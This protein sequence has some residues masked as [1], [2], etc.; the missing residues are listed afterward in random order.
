MLIHKLWDGSEVFRQEGTIYIPFPYPRLVISNS[1]INSGY[2]EDITG[3][4]NH[5]MSPDELEKDNFSQER[6]IQYLEQIALKHDLEKGHTVGMLTAAKMENV[7]IRTMD[8]KELAVTAIVTGGVDVNGGRVGDPA[9]YYELDGTYHF[10]TGTVNIILLVQG[11]LPPY[12]LV[13]SIITATEAKTAAL[14]EL[15]APSCYSTGI[16][17]GSGTD[18]IVVVADPK[19]PYT[20]TDAGKHSKLG[21]LIGITVKEAV[22]EA[23]DK[24]T[25]LN[26][27]TQRNFLARWARY[28]IGLQD[29]WEEAKAWGYQGT[30]EQFAEELQRVSCH[31]L[32]VALASAIIHLLDEYSWGLLDTTTVIN[33]GEKLLNSFVNGNLTWGNL[34]PAPPVYL[35]KLFIRTVLLTQIFN[36]D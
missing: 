2:R 6:V 21:E 16:A 19:S 7:A 23:L 34:N 3:V 17:T 30:Y 9:S 26:P 11:F 1:L 18:Q 24:E 20:F 33:V 25:S 8:Y 13:R 14:Q 10:F 29:F 15:M 28:G 36:Q 22:K 12:A 35:A 4:F 5:C 32:W 27:V 31:E